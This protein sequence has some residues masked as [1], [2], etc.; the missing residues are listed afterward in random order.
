VTVY[1][2]T[3]AVVAVVVDEARSAEVRAWMA[4]SL[5]PMI[6]SELAVL[7]F[8]AVVS[9]AVRTN[10]F[11][12]SQAETALASF[13]MLRA[14]CETLVHD[15]SDFASAEQLVLDFSTKL[16]AP[17]ALHLASAINV[18]A[19]LLTLDERLAEMA[20]S[21]GLGLAKLY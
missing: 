17:D 2:D 18:G 10:R 21:R 12:R 14:G 8:A 16:A 5:E 1:L 11:D 6:L 9:R 7:E 20:R 4:R 15:R 19:R 3:S 13:A